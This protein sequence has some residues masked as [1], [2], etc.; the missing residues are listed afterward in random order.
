M[1]KRV[2]L[3]VAD[4]LGIGDAPDA[5]LYGDEG[6][7]TLGAIRKSGFFNCPNLA[8]LGLFNIDGVGGGAEKPKAGFVRLTE[9][10]A[11]KD[12]ITGHWEIAGLITDRPFPVYPNG[13]PE[14]VIAEFEKETGKKAICNKPY[15]GTEVIK[16][17]GEK[18][19]QSGD[20]IVYTSADSV[21]QIAAHTDSVTEEELYGYCLKARKILSGE[22]AVARV[23]ARPFCGEYP[24][25]RTSGRRDFSL[26]PTGKTM[27]DLIK[28]TGKEVVSIGKIN[29]IFSGRG[30][31]RAVHTDGNESG[32]KETLRA[33]DECTSGLIFVNLVDFDMK[34]G[35]R[36]D[37]DGYAKAMTEFDSELSFVIEKMKDEDLLVIT[38]DHGCDP[39]TPSTDHSR[40]RVPALFYGKSVRSGVNMGTRSSFAD[41][42]AT[43]LDYLGIDKDKTSGESMAKDLFL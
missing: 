26:P 12:T 24:F 35:H 15:S 32:M 29:D 31:T 39:S 18:Q 36:N 42:S 4:S 13:F 43:L 6:S 14:S 40:E 20:L 41:I 22:H 8:S 11:G 7:N 5:A 34:Y 23:I 1:G 17:Y 9:R 33:M 10:S 2:I 37:V 21:F 16:D 30:V 38:A 3:I 27:L 28:G 25:V 19:R